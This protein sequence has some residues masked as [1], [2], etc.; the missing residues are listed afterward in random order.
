MN[1]IGRTLTSRYEHRLRQASEAFIFLDFA[2][3]KR[4]NVELKLWDAH[5]KINARYRKMLARVRSHMHYKSVPLA[6]THQTSSERRMDGKNQCNFAR[7]RNTI[8]NSS[9]QANDSTVATSCASLAN[10]VVFRNWKRLRTA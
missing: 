6:N 9:R 5:G 1:T 7:W 3:A 4:K 2:L 10:S 8:F